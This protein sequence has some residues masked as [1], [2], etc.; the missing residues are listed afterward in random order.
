MKRFVYSKEQLDFIKFGFKNWM[1][2]ELTQKF[3]LEFGLE[4]TSAQIRST[5]KNNGFKCGRKSGAA[6]KGI[7]RSFTQDQAQFIADGY[8][9]MSL[10]KLVDA[11][12]KQYPNTPKTLNQLRSFTRNHK[13]LSGRTGQFKKGHESWN[14][15]L[16]GKGIMKANS[17]TFRLGQ[18][19]ANVRPMYSE[20]ISKDGYVEIKV[21]VANPHTGARTRFMLKHIWLWEQ[22]NGA[23]PAGHMLRFKDGDKMNCVPSNMHLMTRGMNATLNKL[24]YSDAPEELKPT[25]HLICKIHEAVRTAKQTVAAT[26][27]GEV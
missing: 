22:E 27:G 24:G 26:Q 21:P 14:A 13:L 3:N 15:G 18:I 1:L 19:P 9:T 12:N 4:K 17:G 20:R 8:K 10:A 11:F 23:V 7:L 25:V 5:I 16:A 6:N 2:D